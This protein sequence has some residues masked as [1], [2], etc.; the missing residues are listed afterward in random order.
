VSGQ[1]CSARGV[2]VSRLRAEVWLFHES[3]WI[4]QVLEYPVD[5]DG[6]WRGLF[7]IPQL[8][9]HVSYGPGFGLQGICLACF[10]R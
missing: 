1:G 10:L 9:G 6:S 3:G 8:Y 7:Q 2:A 4:V 5:S